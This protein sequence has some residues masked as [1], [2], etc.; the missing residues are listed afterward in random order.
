MLSYYTIWFK[1]FWYN[2][3]PR[4]SFIMRRVLTTLFS[5]E[6]NSLVLRSR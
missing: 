6:E 2:N 3:S 1:T 4:H 5:S